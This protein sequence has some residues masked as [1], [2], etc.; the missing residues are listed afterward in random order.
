MGHARHLSDIVVRSFVISSVR[1]GIDFGL[2]QPHETIVLNFEREAS[3]DSNLNVVH[4]NAL[5]AATIPLRGALASMRP[6]VLWALNGVFASSR[7]EAGPS[8]A[9]TLNL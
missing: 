6:M 5:N 9:K 1:L 7:S 2:N 8:I 4:E 3:N